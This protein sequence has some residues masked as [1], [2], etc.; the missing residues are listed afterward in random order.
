MRR[1]KP[2]YRQAANTYS[3]S[4]PV[5]TQARVIASPLAW[6]W[7]SSAGSLTWRLKQLSPNFAVTLMKSG[8]GFV[9][10]D[11]W[12]SIA[13]PKRQQVWQRDVCLTLDDE[14][15][16]VAHSITSLTGV[17]QVWKSLYTLARRPLAEVLFTDPSVLRL[18]LS[19]AR[20]NPFHP[21]YQQVKQIDKHLSEPLWARRSIFVRNNT[22]LMVTEIFLPALWKRIYR[23][24]DA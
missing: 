18:P 10:P 14:P 16:V 21:L 13:L 11:E 4:D 5:W 3:L 15:M 17:K 8:H 12:A 6:R 2:R 24:H 23:S 7:L 9:L 20:I 1:M 19:Y 22:P